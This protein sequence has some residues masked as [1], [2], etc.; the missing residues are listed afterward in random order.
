VEAVIGYS[1]RAQPFRIFECPLVQFLVIIYTQLSVQ[2][3]KR[4]NIV[5]LKIKY[6]NSYLGFA[7]PLLSFAPKPDECVD[8]VTFYKAD[9][10]TCIHP[11]LFFKIYKK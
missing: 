1:N 6:K 3:I 7:N 4:P 8:N 10:H 9:L 11:N 5:V 2:D